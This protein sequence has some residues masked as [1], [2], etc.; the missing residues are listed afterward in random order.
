MERQTM[1]AAVGGNRVE[2]TL[3]AVLELVFADAS[4]VKERARR[5]RS[6]PRHVAERGIAE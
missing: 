4:D 1:L 2:K 5:A 6:Y 3:S